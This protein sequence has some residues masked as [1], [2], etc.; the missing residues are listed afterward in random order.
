MV[1]AATGTAPE[2]NCAPVTEPNGAARLTG[3]AAV[4]VTV[5]EMVVWP[6]KMASSMVWLAWISA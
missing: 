3:L 2:R 1:C 5:G 6:L 4:P